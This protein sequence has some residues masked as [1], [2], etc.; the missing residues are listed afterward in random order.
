MNI[1]GCTVDDE[2]IPNTCVF[3]TV[4]SQFFTNPPFGPPDDPVLDV[5]GNFFGSNTKCAEEQFQG[6]CGNNV[7]IRNIGPVSDPQANPAFRSRGDT[8]VSLSASTSQSSISLGYDINSVDGETGDVVGTEYTFGMSKTL[9]T[10]TASLITLDDFSFPAL[11]FGVTVSGSGIAT[12]IFQSGL[13]G[14]LQVIGAS[15]Q[16]TFSYVQTL[17]DGRP[18]FVI[19]FSGNALVR[20]INL[21]PCCDPA[22]ITDPRILDRLNKQANGGGCAG[23]GDG[24]NF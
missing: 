15:F 2:G 16:W 7:I 23:C 22:G 8:A 9:F 5:Q 19:Q 20:V 14:K 12:P 17:N 10:S 18:D 1:L 24:N 4:E 11:G 6:C 21:V 3:G 13:N